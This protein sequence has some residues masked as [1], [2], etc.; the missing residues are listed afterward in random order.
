[1]GVD[2]DPIPVESVG[3][4]GTVLPLLPAPVYYATP[5]NGWSQLIVPH[6]KS[7]TSVLDP[8]AAAYF[9]E[10]LPKG[11]GIPEAN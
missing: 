7:W 3:V 9:F 4:A 10:G 6:L 2:M 8:E 1:M 5:E 11:E